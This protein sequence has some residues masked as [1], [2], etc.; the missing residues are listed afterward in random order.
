MLK[1]TDIDAINS[2]K[3]GQIGGYIVIPSNFSENMKNALFFKFILTLRQ[4]K[5]LPLLSD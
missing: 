3:L 5:D 4:F 2:V 1:S